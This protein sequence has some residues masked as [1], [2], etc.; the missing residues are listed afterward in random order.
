MNY[1]FFLAN[2]VLRIPRFGFFAPL[3]FHTDG[4]LLPAEYS[5][6]QGETKIEIESRQKVILSCS[7]NKFWSIA[8]SNVSQEAESH[9]AECKG[10][11]TL[12][13]LSGFTVNKC[14]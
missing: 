9:E 13:K 11:Q 8:I 12:R 4:T 10:E 7:P 1:L 14:F 2:C 5:E 6:N 3:I